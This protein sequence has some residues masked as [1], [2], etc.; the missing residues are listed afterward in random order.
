MPHL[1]TKFQLNQLTVFKSF[2]KTVGLS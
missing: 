1:A 2:T